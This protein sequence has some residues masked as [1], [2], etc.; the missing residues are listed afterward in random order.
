MYERGCSWGVASSDTQDKWA[1]NRAVLAIQTLL[2]YNG[3]PVQYASAPGVFGPLTDASTRAFQAVH[4]APADGIVGPNTT[5]ALLRKIV[6]AQE[7]VNGVPDRILWGQIG[8]ETSW[9]LGCIGYYTPLDLGIC[10]FNLYYNANISPDEAMNPQYVIPISAR[11]LR[12]RFNE[13]RLL[14]SD[15]TRAWDAAILSHNSPVRARAYAKTGV[16]PTAQAA[17]YVSKVRKASK[18]A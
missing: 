11:R 3:F 15:V 4:A 17:D 10:Q 16:Y 13:Y 9:D 5:R 12:T 2:G 6:A 7:K 8:A 14:T 18:I 1:V